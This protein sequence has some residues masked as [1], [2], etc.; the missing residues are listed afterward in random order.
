MT[1]REDMARRVLDAALALV[2]EHGTDELR[3]LINVRCPH[4]GG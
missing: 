3:V 2:T 1:R 4:F